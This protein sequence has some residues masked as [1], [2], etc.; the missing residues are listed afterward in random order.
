MRMKVSIPS[1]P[2]TSSLPSKERQEVQLPLL[3][4]EALDSPE[5]LVP[6]RQVRAGR[7]LSPGEA[8]APQFPTRQRAPP[9]PQDW[10]K[11]AEDR[12]GSKTSPQGGARWQVVW[13]QLASQRAP[14]AEGLGHLCRGSLEGWS[15]TGSTAHRSGS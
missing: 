3:V 10:R 14:P 5:V 6:V 2:A 13:L 1:V 11:G 7:S 4:W 8:C 9:F 15:V 12:R